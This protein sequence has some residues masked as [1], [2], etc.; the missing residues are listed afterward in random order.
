[1]TVPL[2]QS[3]ED[4][5]NPMYYETPSG[6]A[7]DPSLFNNDGDEP[8]VWIMTPRKIGNRNRVEYPTKVKEIVSTMEDVIGF[9][10]RVVVHPY[11]RL[12]PNS[13]DFSIFNRG[14]FGN[15]VFQ[16]DTDFDKTGEGHKAW[17]LFYEGQL[18]SRTVPS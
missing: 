9:K 16:Y 14:R 11:D 3:P 13:P 15:A 2:P 10:P 8:I 7:L 1:M 17:R 12:D 5:F 4:G 18:S 6:P